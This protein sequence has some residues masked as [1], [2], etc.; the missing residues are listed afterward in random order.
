[1]PYAFPNARHREAAR[2]GRHTPVDDLRDAQIDHHTGK[3]EG[4]LTV[5]LQ[6]FAH[7]LEHVRECDA[8]RLVQVLVEAEG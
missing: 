8:H 4:L 2:R 3:R 6:K 7:Q 1:M 5:D